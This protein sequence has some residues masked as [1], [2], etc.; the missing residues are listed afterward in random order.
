MA[1]DLAEAGVELPTLMAAGRWASSR[2]PALYNAAHGARA[3]R[4]GAVLRPFGVAA[5]PSPSCRAGSR[6]RAI[7]A[8]GAGPRSVGTTPIA[9]PAVSAGRSPKTP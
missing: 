6:P 1:E 5:P 4:G 9:A 7:L 8:S 2:M 3:P